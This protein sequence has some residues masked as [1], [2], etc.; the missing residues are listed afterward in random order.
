M[1]HSLSRLL[2][3][4]GLEQ[5]S[6]GLWIVPGTEQQPFAYSDGDDAED[7]VHEVIA[8]ASDTSSTSAELE[9]YIRD[10]PSEY[11]FTSKRATLLRALDLSGMEHVR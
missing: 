11:H 10:W 3:E 9:R 4:N 6:E 1:T 7:Y 8:N 5:G 2:T